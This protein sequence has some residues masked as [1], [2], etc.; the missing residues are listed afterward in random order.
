MNYHYR[1]NV[2]YGIRLY[3]YFDEVEFVFWSPKPK[4]AELSIKGLD[5]INYNNNFANY[6][7]DYMHILSEIR[8]QIIEFKKDKARG[9]CSKTPEIRT[10]EISLIDPK[11]LDLFYIKFIDIE[12]FKITQEDINTLKILFTTNPDAFFREKSYTFNKCIID[13]TTHFNTTPIPFLMFT[14]SVIEDFSSLNNFAGE[15]LTLRNNQILDYTNNIRLECSI[16]TLDDS[17]IDPALLFLKTTADKV[18]RLEMYEKKSFDDDD[19]RFISCF[20][21]IT[22]LQTNAIVREHKSIDKLKYLTQCYGVGVPF[23]AYEK[24][25][26]QNNSREMLIFGEHKTDRIRRIKNQRTENTQFRKREKKLKWLRHNP[27][28]WSYANN[29]DRWRKRLLVE[30][31]KNTH[32]SRIKRVNSLFEYYSQR[33]MFPEMYRLIDFSE[34]DRQIW[35]NKINHYTFEE[36]KEDFQKIE[37]QRRK[38]ILWAL[39]APE[40]GIVTEEFYTINYQRYRLKLRSTS[41]PFADDDGIEYIE[42]ETPI[43]LAKSLSKELKIEKNKERIPTK[44]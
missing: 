28:R 40:E 22:L 35:E 36:I 3:V 37:Q 34:E 8:Q 27:S 31:E 13:K 30:R 16:L 9:T 14:R 41:L 19:M 21:N 23:S 11:R 5:R 44:W 38:W 33:W 15:Y 12:N 18:K 7:F 17:H 20:P 43:I 32:Q 1:I 39:T 2:D 29:Y 24:K 25:H 42:P 26:R 4:E 10:P 6:F